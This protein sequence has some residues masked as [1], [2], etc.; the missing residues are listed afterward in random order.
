MR[1]YKKALAATASTAALAL[2]GVAAGPASANS[3]GCT[4]ISNWSLKGFGIDNVCIDIKGDGN[5]ADSMTASF[6]APTGVANPRL[7]LTSFDVNGVQQN[8]WMSSQKL[9]HRLGESFTVKNVDLPTG[10]VCAE[11]GASG[12]WAP[13]ACAAIFP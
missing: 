5:H 13:G 11:V 7:R 1:H 4:S 9:G 6:A 10:K 8:Q 12:S 2:A 3:S